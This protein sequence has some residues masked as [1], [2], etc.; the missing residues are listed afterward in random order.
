[1]WY[2]SIIMRSNRGLCLYWSR[3]W[4]LSAFEGGGLAAVLGG[5]RKG[6]KLLSFLEG[7]AF[8][9]PLAMVKEGSLPKKSG[10][11]CEIQEVVWVMKCW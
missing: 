7:L 9:W 3:G 1:M 10:V 4:L 8:L 2:P 11:W 6:K 5:P